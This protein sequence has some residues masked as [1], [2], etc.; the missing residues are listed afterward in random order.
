MHHAPRGSRRYSFGFGALQ[1]LFEEAFASAAWKQVGG[2][3]FRM[4][5]DE[6]FPL[7]GLLS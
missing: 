5:F 6:S 1:V 4:V 2:S 7:P 3:K